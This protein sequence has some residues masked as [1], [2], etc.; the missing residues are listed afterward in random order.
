[1]VSVAV[2]K[3]RELGLD[4]V[5]CA[6]TGNLANSVAAQAAAA[7]LRA[8]VFIPVG[9]EA[10]KVIGTLVY[11]PTVFA[12][13]GSYDDVNRLCSELADRRPWGFVN[14]NLRP[15][16]AEGSKTVG[17]EIAEQLGWRTPAHVVVPCAGGSLLTKI[18]KAFAELADLGLVD[19]RPPRMHAAQ[20]AG[21]GPIVT[22]IREGSD[23]LVPVRPRTVAKSLAI[24]NPADGYYAA[25]AVRES[26]GWAAHA[27]DEEILEAMELLAQAEGIF[28]ETA[29]GVTLAAARKLV[30][31]G[32]IGRDEPVVVCITG[33]GLKTVE[34][35]EPR[36]AEPLRVGASLAAVEAVLPELQAITT[37]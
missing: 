32:R 13:E 20:A 18:G 3:A 29:G 4:T 19:G 26:D 31:E 24:G 14:V 35:L 15:Y 23:V 36:L 12:V 21:C 30:E 8:F 22:M 33:S 7:G 2:S 6:S 25:Q 1:M 9:L 28:A 27:A 10:G 37:R 16:Y 5:A 17:Y 34:A 11:G